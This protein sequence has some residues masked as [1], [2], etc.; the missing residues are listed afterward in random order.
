[1]V[2]DDEYAGKLTQDFLVDSGF[3]VDRFL[4]A[5][6]TIAHIHHDHYYLLLLDITL[7]DYDGFEILKALK[8]KIAIPIIVISAHAL[9]EYKLKAFKLG[10]VDYMTKPFDLEELE[11]RVWLALNKT[12]RIGL[13]IDIFEIRSMT[14][15]FNNNTLALTHIEFELLKTLILSKNM[16]VPRRTLADRLSKISSERSL[17]YHIKNI[18][19]KIYDSDPH[20]KYIITEYGVG[21]RLAV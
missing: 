19:K 13:N 20:K 7:P 1:M 18:R 16:V 17:D 8:N 6:D 9:T 12:S 14:I 2:E 10:A 21:Y 3:K 5:T 15:L 11:A 4:T